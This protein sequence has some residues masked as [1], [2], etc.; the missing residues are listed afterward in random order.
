MPRY[1]TDYSK[2]AINLT[3]PAEVRNLLLEYNKARKMETIHQAALEATAEFKVL[4]QAQADVGKLY[5]KLQEA[6]DLAGS[7][8]DI[9]EG[10]YGLKQSRTSVTFDPK[11]VR[12][13]I[14]QFA[15]AVIMETVDGTK[16]NGL[17]KGGLITEAQVAKIEVRAALSPAYIIGIAEQPVKGKEGTNAD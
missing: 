12:K 9:A 8:Q 10:L 6:I 1:G 3:N 17:K 5:D 2:T 16:V 15:E 14:P 11:A 7:Y 13:V 4:A